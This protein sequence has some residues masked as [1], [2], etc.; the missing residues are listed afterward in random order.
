MSNIP[1]NGKNLPRDLHSSGPK[2]PSKAEAV[3]H[4]ISQQEKSAFGI[5]PT[6]KSF[7]LENPELCPVISTFGN[8]KSPT[9]QKWEKISRSMLAANKDRQ[10]GD[11]VLYPKALFQAE[12]KP[13]VLTLFEQHSIDRGTPM[14]AIPNR[15]REAGDGMEP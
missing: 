14:A 1:T 10:P 9:K 3:A 11:H 2:V 8:P 7:L 5:D 4:W 15:S 6:V 13:E 12:F